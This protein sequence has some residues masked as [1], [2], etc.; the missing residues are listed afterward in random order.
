MKP[1]RYLTVLLAALL[2][3][4]VGA[5]QD[6]TV[7]L[8]MSASDPYRQGFVRLINHSNDEGI[9]RVRAFDDT[10]RAYRVE[11]IP[12][13]EYQTVHFNSDDL[14]LGNDD[15]GIRGIGSGQG[16]WRLVISADVDLEVLTYIR[17][18]DG[19]LTS[20]QDVV[21][22]LGGLHRV[23]TF[24]PGSNTAQQS[25]LRLVNAGDDDATIT[26]KGVDD[27]GVVSPEVEVE[28]AAGIS[29]TLTAQQL[30]AGDMSIKGAIGDGEGKWQL[31]L[32]AD[33]PVQI[34]S[35]M[36][37]PTGHLT[38]LA[39]TERPSLASDVPG[40]GIKLIEEFAL[41]SENSFPTGM[42]F[43]QNRFYVLN[44]SGKVFAYTDTGER[45]AAA[46]IEL[47]YRPIPAF[48][49]QPVERAV[50][51]GVR[52]DR[53]Y[54]FHEDRMRAYMLSGAEDPDASFAVT[55]HTV[56]DMA[57]GPERFYFVGTRGFGSSGT[58][59]LVYDFE[60]MFKDG[61][62][63]LKGA[64]S[65]QPQAIAYDRRTRYLYIINDPHG[66]TINAF[67]LEGKEEKG[68]VVPFGGLSNIGAAT[69]I[70]DA[71]YLLEDRENKVYGIPLRR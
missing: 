45:D 2:A 68:A 34:M 60:H 46:D 70:G 53:L 32:E 62:G 1:G 39:T 42:T 69:I 17:T 30:E 20:M 5:Q 55:N 71:I 27:A 16:D 57:V 54:V 40:E 61:E 21:S 59:V 52:G 63:F 19:F 37:T 36:S 7:P 28:L 23:P 12:L 9:V 11:T 65:A 51:L 33:Q 25:L 48:G 8:F 31:F 47:T 13:T 10:G 24:N 43:F 15:K 3:T 66:G 29:T 41:A 50:G 14:E 26:L 58:E 6:T 56:R 18:R 67:T 44:Y 64:D 49:A 4:S 22:S 38:N 35:L